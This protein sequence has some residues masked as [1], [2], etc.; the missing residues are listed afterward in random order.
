[1]GGSAAGGT[2]FLNTSA[3]S[4]SSQIV[5]TDSNG[6]APVVLTL[7]LNPGTVHVSAEGQYGLGHPEVVFTET[8]N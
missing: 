8:A 6:N 3:G 5:T 4:L 7:P 2:I 1:S